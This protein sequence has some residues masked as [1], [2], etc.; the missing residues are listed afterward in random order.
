M[1]LGVDPKVAKKQLK[2]NKK[3]TKTGEK[4][5]FC[6]FSVA[7]LLLSGRPRKSLFHYVFR[8]FES[9]G[10]SGSVG[11]FAPH[12]LRFKKWSLNALNHKSEKSS[13]ARNFFARA[14]GA[15]YGCANFY[16]R[17]ASFG[18]LCWK[19][20]SLRSCRSSSV[21]F[22]CFFAGKFGKF[23]GKFGGNFPDFF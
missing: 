2:S 10:V 4:L 13:C 19:T 18:F 16:G 17:L 3:V 22:F 14:S 6:Y 20:F 1:T 9:F 23:S 5:L 12:K 11:P 8:Y 15:G 7:F 21:I